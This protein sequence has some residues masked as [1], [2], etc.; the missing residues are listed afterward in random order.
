[1]HDNESAKV[2]MGEMEVNCYKVLILYMKWYN[3][4]V[5]LHLKICNKP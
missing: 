1:M 3:V 2:G 5:K 4:K